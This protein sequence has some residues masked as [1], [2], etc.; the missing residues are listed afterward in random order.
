MELSR[1]E[2]LFGKGITPDRE[3]LDDPDVR[4]RLL[5]RAVG[6]AGRTPGFGLEIVAGHI[7]ADDPPEVWATAQRLLG[8]GLDRDRVLS[9]LVIAFL[10]TAREGAAEGVF[11]REAYGVALSRLPLPE[12]D[13]AERV[14]TEVVRGEPG[15]EA[16]RLED[17]VIER[18]GCASDDEIARE[19]VGR[20]MDELVDEDGPLA[21]LAGDRTFHVGDLTSGIVL[22]H[23]LNDVERSVGLLN[24]AFDLGGFRRRD[25]LRLSN[26]DLI[27]V[28]APDAGSLV[29]FN[30]HGWLERFEPDDLVTVRVSEDGVV[31]LGVV[32]AELKPD[33]ALVERLRAVYD[34]EVEEAWLPVPAED[35]VLGLQFED[36][37]SFAEPRLPLSELAAAAGLEVRGTEAAHE[38]SVWY[39]L[40]LG[41]R[42][43]RVL[44]EVED[45]R[46][47]S[48]R[49]LRILDL[50]DIAAGLDPAL[51]A[52]VTG[53]GEPLSARQVLEFL[54]DDEVLRV[55]TNE[56]FDGPDPDG[57]ERARPFVDLLVAAADRPA[58]TGVAQLFAALQAERIGD[59][60]AAEAHLEIGVAA[61]PSS[62]LLVDRLAWYASDRGDAARAAR[63]WRSLPRRGSIDGQLATLE[64]MLARTEARSGRNDPCWCGSGRKYKLCHLGATET[65]PLPDRVGWLCRKAVNF[66]ERYGP[67]AEDDVFAV[68]TARALDPDDTSSIADAFGDPIVMDLTLTEGG[69][70]ERFLEERGPLLPDDELLLAQSWMLVERTVYEVLEARPGESVDLRDLRT[71]DKL[72]V[73]ERTFSRETRPGALVCAR[74]VPD[75]SSHQFVGGLFPVTP[76]TEGAVL[77]LLD[78]GDPE[79]I[80]D[81]VARLYRPPHLQNREGE[82]ILDCQV[83]AD[84]GD[85]SQTRAGLDDLYERDPTDPDSWVESHS[86]DNGERILRATLTLDGTLVTIRTNSDERAD[87]VIATLGAR[88]PALRVRSDRRTP[89]DLTRDEL[90]G[91]EPEPPDLASDLPP[92]VIDQ[93]CDQLERRWCEETVPALGGVTPRQAAE[94]P[95]R[96][97]EL[98]RLIASFDDMPVPPGAIGMRPERLRRLL[99]LTPT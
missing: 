97:G 55:V 72:N 8:E 10:A 85:D 86:L 20:V 69:W 93:I 88:F 60:V 79:T 53:H 35:L 61:D 52:E 47:L 49:I 92:E 38:E 6:S 58:D 80:A 67:T 77:D 81:H 4:A 31:E 74:A 19:L 62:A 5:Q 66:L 91:D 64:P 7:C 17:V 59:L 84:T 65:P 99:G 96:R 57:A 42:T 12:A 83:V 32:D 45:D 9:Q 1:L 21:W 51:V 50:A 89:F 28:V 73:R 18:L 98:T 25:G 43:W 95:T 24:A 2:F 33:P 44:H 90:Q 54:D 27:D 70:F 30:A 15:I 36:A 41:Q 40:S 75:G 23:R 26:G 34:D 29:W 22:T 71:G 68:A 82:E 76:G 16:D 11:D 37:G 48:D 78:E 3:D 14:L 94:D 39:Q 13:E 63:L 46:S 56:L 87:R